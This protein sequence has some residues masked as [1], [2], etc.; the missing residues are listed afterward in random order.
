MWVLTPHRLVGNNQKLKDKDC[1]KQVQRKR[2]VNQLVEVSAGLETYQHLPPDKAHLRE[3]SSRPSRRLL[4]PPSASASS[5]SGV[6]SGWTSARG[7]GLSLGQA[8]SGR[9]AVC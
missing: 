9:A 5:R 7:A 2:N 1:G 4:G 8:L 6:S 3:D